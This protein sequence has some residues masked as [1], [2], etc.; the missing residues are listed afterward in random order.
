[1]D[2]ILTQAVWKMR[3]QDD[4]LAGK[5]IN[6][7]LISTGGG[8]YQLYF[9]TKGCEYAC[10]MCNY[11]FEHPVRENKIMEELE[12]L[13]TNNFPYDTNNLILEASGSFLDERELPRYLQ[14]SIMKRVA[15]INLPKVQIET[16][17]KTITKER[18]EEIKSIF[19][20]RPVSFELGLES[21]QPEVFNIYNKSMDL[22]RLL[23]TIWM[24][25]EN[26]IEVSLNIMLGAPLMTI[27]EQINDTLRSVNWIVKN[28]PKETEIVLFPVNIKDYTLVRYWYDQGRYDI[29][30][31]WEFVELLQ[32][33]PKDVLDRI[34]I[35]W[36]G[37]RCNE[38]HGEEAIIKPYHC[39][40]C[41]DE[42]KAF[43]RNFVECKDEATEKARLLKKISSYNCKCRNEY[44]IKKKFQKRINK[45]YTERLEEEK[46][47][48]KAELNL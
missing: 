19:S 1:M 7:S 12:K 5:D 8:S 43:Y 10:T 20:Y 36:Y 39:S 13:L 3:K 31:D 41:D 37:N 48:L 14:V 32:R 46:K 16:H 35:S 2:K 28:C 4:N 45:S 29:V 27:E 18:I 26:K 34:Y 44:E 40:E 17:Y 21:T 9:P 23:K 15:K 25:D 6:V 47:H 22:E 38:F 11:G 33:L 24:C 42:L 30:S